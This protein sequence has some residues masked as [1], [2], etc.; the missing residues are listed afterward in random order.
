[1]PWTIADA[2]KSLRTTRKKRQWVRIANSVL[3]RCL[4]E[5]GDQQACEASALRQAN[6]VLARN[7]GWPMTA[8]LFFTA[9]TFEG[10][11]RQEML[12][13]QLHYVR[14]LKI[15]RPMVLHGLGSNG[16]G[17]LLPSQELRRCPTAAWNNVPL[18][19][20]HPFIQQGHD[21]VYASAADP[22]MIQRFKIGQIFNAHFDDEGRLAGEAWLDVD[23]CNLLGGD[24]KR[25]L[26]L[27]ESSDTCDVS[28]AYHFERDATPGQVNGEAYNAVQRNI[29]PDH[30]ALLLDTKGACSQPDGCG[31][32]VNCATCHPAP[33]ANEATSDAAIISKFFA[34]M[35][36]W[37]GA[38]QTFS[39]QHESARVALR[40][41]FGAEDMHFLSDIED[42]PRRVIFERN[43]QLLALPFSVESNRVVLADEKPMPVQRSTS[44]IA[45]NTQ[46]VVSQLIT[47]ELVHKRFRL[48]LILEIKGKG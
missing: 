44:F 25:A 40:E 27:F 23:A 12:Q 21:K 22:G 29:H 5:G 30:V 36:H 13:G 11:V 16:E 32:G 47:S 6:G 17:Q 2:P 14:P 18:T 3:A 39:D 26:A 43:G 15:V 28:S 45:A 20:G 1:M 41:R 4:D 35:K 7:E 24:A 19:L 33:S 37:L 46:A 10:G 31:L 38:Q 8:T 34:Y 42:A 48:Y 9:A